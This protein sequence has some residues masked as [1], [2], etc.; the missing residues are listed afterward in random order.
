MNR[1]K[2]LRHL[3]FRM[4]YLAKK[5]AA[6][7]ANHFVLAEHSALSWVLER[8]REVVPTRPVLADLQKAHEDSSP[9]PWHVVGAPWGDGTYVIAGNPDPHAGK[10]VADCQVIDEDEISDEDRELYRREHANAAFI[11]TAHN[12]WPA[13]IA[14]IQTLEQALVELGE[15]VDETKDAAALRALRSRVDAGLKTVGVR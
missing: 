7:D 8:L 9:G 1:R 10:F 6:G 14:R 4:I 2:A 12:A 15:I 5:I 11:A 13:L 3:E